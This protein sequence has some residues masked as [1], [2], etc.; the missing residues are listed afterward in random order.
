MLKKS[1]VAKQWLRPLPQMQSHSCNFW[2]NWFIL[3]A[4]IF[5]S[6]CSCTDSLTLC[7][8]RGFQRERLCPEQGLIRASCLPFIW[9]PIKYENRPQSAAP[10]FLVKATAGIII[11][12]RVF[13]SDVTFCQTPLFPTSPGASAAAALGHPPGC[14]GHVGG[15]NQPSPNRRAK[16]SLRAPARRYLQGWRRVCGFPV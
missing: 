5:V 2:G 13:V 16:R 7:I 8:V 12:P 11:Q 15:R 1:K 14:L 3:G 6:R 9:F 4:D 10:I